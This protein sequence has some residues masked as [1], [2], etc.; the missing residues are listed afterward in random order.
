MTEE[1]DESGK[2]EKEQQTN[3]KEGSPS[4]GAKAKP[5]HENVGCSTLHE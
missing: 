2:Q 4:K 3:T 1:P 5:V